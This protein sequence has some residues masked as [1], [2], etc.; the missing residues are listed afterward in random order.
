[1]PLD[2]KGINYMEK[3]KL[4]KILDGG[5]GIVA[6]L[7]VYFMVL[8]PPSGTEWIYSWMEF[9]PVL[10]ISGYG[11][12]NWLVPLI[13]KKKKEKAAEEPKREQ[14]AKPRMPFF[15]RLAMILIAVIYAVF[16]AVLLFHAGPYTKADRYLKSP[17][18]KHKA[19]VIENRWDDEEIY[20]VKSLLFYED[21]KGVDIN[22]RR[23]DITLAWVENYML[24][25]TRTDKYTGEVETEYLRW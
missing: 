7:P 12:A 8:L 23:Y 25:I 16:G 2:R 11:V 24:E 5:W 1:M 13:A 10:I 14:T 9:V 22:P 3:T 6:F 20:P 19:V 4:Q 15:L 18:G 21:N 17:D